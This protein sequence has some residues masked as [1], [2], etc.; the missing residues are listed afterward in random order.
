MK[1]KLNC[2]EFK[3]CGF[4]PDGRNAE[5]QGVCPAALDKE[6]DGVNGGQAAGRFCWMIE[7]TTCNNLNVI[8]FK[9]IKCTECDFY[10][11][12]EKEENR[13]LVLTKWDLNRDHLRVNLG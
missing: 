2:W 1:N 4:E 8:A 6:F 10:Q 12:V 13:S 9:F 7:N 3:D 5:V 11:L